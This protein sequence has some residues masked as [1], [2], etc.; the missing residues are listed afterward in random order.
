MK[1]IMLLLGGG[2]SVGIHLAASQLTFDDTNCGD[3]VFRGD[4]A[5]Q[6]SDKNRRYI[7]VEKCIRSYA[8][9]EEW[10]AE[11]GNGVGTNLARVEKFR[12]QVFPAITQMEQIYAMAAAC[13][14]ENVPQI[15]GLESV[16][17]IALRSNANDNNQWRWGTN[18]D[19]FTDSEILQPPGATLE[20]GDEVSLSSFGSDTV[21]MDC[22]G[23]GPIPVPP[24]T[25]SCVVVDVRDPM[26]AANW[27]VVDNC[28]TVSS[29]EWLAPGFLCD[30]PNFCGDDDFCED[31]EF[32]PIEYIPITPPCF[33]PPTS[34]PTSG[35]SARPSSVPSSQPSTS[36][37][38]TSPSISP[39]TT[40]SISPS[41]MPSSTSSPSASNAPSISLAPSLS[42]APS[43]CSKKSCDSD[44]ILS[45]SGKRRNLKSRESSH[46]KSKK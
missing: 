4:I 12:Y 9:A 18:T 23:D 24:T 38:S 41:T 29:T 44:N 2:T 21:G 36:S 7:Y 40:P 34:G 14:D 35:P 31:Q 17:L 15:N 22:I 28:D 30:N 37:P 46:N 33:E 26:N 6:L 8:A 10:C 1:I 25:E 45:R 42:S 5:S 11:P 3:G 13:G 39:S 16:C 19:S 20:V 43:A 32:N 27:V